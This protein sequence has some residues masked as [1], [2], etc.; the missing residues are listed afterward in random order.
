MVRYPIMIEPIPDEDGGGYAAFFPDLPG[1]MSD[2][3]SP[4]E[5]VQNAMDALE[6]WTAVQVER[7][8]AMPEPGAAQAEFTQSLA[9]MDAEIIRLTE[10]LEHAKERIKKLEASK[11]QGWQVRQFRGGFIRQASFG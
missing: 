1:C 8:V 4:T 3:E 11:A 7:G 5:A 10:E 2:G 9:D 6:C